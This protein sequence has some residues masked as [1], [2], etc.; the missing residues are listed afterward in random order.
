MKT[1]MERARKLKDAA[2]RW[3]VAGDVQRHLHALK[4]LMDLRTRPIGPPPL[5]S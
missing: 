1:N 2:T 5:G 4:L 3:M